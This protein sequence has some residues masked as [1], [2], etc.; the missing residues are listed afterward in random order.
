MDYFHRNGDS[1]PDFRLGCC[2]RKTGA[3]ANYPGGARRIHGAFR[4]HIEDPFVT[5]VLYASSFEGQQ[6]PS[7]HYRHE[8]GVPAVIKNVCELTGGTQ[9][10][11]M[12]QT[13]ENRVM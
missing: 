10:A 1:V 5:D 13:Y 12:N 7:G 4:G 11:Q 6:H 9:P 2:V 8:H 3:A